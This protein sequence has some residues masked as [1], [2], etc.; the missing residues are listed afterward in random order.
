M[1]KMDSRTEESKKEDGNGD[2]KDEEVTRTTRSY[3]EQQ[4][5][6]TR[7]TGEIR[8]ALRLWSKQVFKTGG[9]CKCWYMRPENPSEEG[10]CNGLHWVM[11]N[12]QELWRDILNWKHQE[13]SRKLWRVGSMSSE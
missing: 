3:F 8:R 11:Y 9:N 7:I 10:G 1:L 4:Q 6:V 13:V 2:V 12:N 5:H